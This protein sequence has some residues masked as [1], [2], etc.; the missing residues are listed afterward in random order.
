MNAALRHLIGKICHMYLDNIVIWSNLVAEHVNH[1]DMVIKAPANTKL[2]CNRKKCQFFMMELDFLGHH[3]SAHG[4]KLNSS[5]IQRILDWPT[6]VNSMDIHTFLGLVHYIVNFLPTLA[7]YTR[8]L[9]PL[10]TKEA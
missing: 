1:I 2:F 6:P 9:T 10:M 8:V 7:D 3:I 5:K 4:I